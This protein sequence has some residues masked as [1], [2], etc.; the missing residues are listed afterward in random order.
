MAVR[1]QQ[2][3]EPLADV[4]PDD[5]VGLSLPPMRLLS[6]SESQAFF[7]DMTR[8]LLGIS[9]DEF[10]RRYHTGRYDDILDDPHHSDLIYLAMLGGL[11]R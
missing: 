10:I 2:I 4:D 3:D 6:V 11:G 5:A 8:K 1:R 7:D 9:G